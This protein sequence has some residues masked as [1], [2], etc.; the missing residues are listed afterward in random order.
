VWDV[1]E[2]AICNGPGKS[3]QQQGGNSTQPK[4]S[5][6][7]TPARVLEGHVN[8]KNFVGLSVGGGDLIAC[9]SE[10]NEVFVYHK[11]FDRPMVRY[12]FDDDSS[13]VGANGA[14]RAHGADT[15]GGPDMPAHFISATCWRGEDDI[16]LV[17]N[18]SGS[19]KALQV[20]E[21]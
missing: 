10:T 3:T 1:R 4:Q 21:A 17:A 8:E 6:K 18:S 7:F 16:L 9:G 15:T 5:E 2:E 12:G 11:S 14:L 13:G 20:V 19:I